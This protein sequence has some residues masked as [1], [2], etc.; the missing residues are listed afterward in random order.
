MEAQNP[1][2]GA[3]GRNAGKDAFG[4]M[5]DKYYP[6]VYNFAY[7]RLVR[8]EAAEDVTSSVFLTARRKTFGGSTRHGET[9]R[10][11]FWSLRGTR[12]AIT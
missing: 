1:W 6:L 4:A 9:S 10:Y 3:L 7:A 12:S 2:Y 11:G 8:R 5:Y